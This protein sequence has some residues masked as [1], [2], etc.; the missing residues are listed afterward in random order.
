MHLALRITPL[1]RKDGTATSDFDI[2][3]VRADTKNLERRAARLGE[4]QSEQR[5][6]IN[7]SIASTGNLP[8]ASIRSNVILSLN[9]SIARQKP[10]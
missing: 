4:R 6:L 8:F 5:V 2:V 10:A 1:K 3:A 9:V 7:A